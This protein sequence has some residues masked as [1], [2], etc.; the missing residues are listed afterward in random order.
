VSLLRVNAMAF[1]TGDVPC[2]AD[3][4]LYLHGTTRGP[5]GCLT[6]R[7][8]PDGPA[9][10][11]VHGYKYSPYHPRHCPHRRIFDTGGWP[12]GLAAQK[13]LAIAFGWHARG[14]LRRIHDRAIRR[15]ADLA[16][17]IALLR[18]NRPN[19]PV[20][21]IA[22]SLGATVAMAALPH[23][24]AGDIGRIVLLTGACHG[25]LAERGLRTPAGRGAKVLNIISRENDL[26]DFAFEHLVPGSGAIGRGTG[27]ANV[28]DLQID[29]SQTLSAL[30]ALGYPV[31]PAERRICHWSAYTRPGVMPLYRAFLQGEGPITPDSLRAVLPV[32]PAPRWSRLLPAHSLAAALKTR[33]MALRKPEGPNHEHAY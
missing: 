5:A 20:H 4:G 6:G 27:L 28:L 19:Q 25:E 2:A 7:R 18:A 15:G 32:A 13:G 31:A 1:D 26:F 8:L 10:I 21:I 24:Q 29:C 3:A 12:A 30:G 11:M 23:L 22:H 33:I 16:R 14:G 9:V 17:M